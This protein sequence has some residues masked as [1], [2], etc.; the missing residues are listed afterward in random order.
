MVPLA[1]FRCFDGFGG[2]VPMFR[3]LVHGHQA[4]PINT[5]LISNHLSVLKASKKIIIS[6]PY[7]H[8]TYFSCPS[9]EISSTSCS[10]RLSMAIPT[11][12]RDAIL[13]QEESCCALSRMSLSSSLPV[14]CGFL[15]QCT[16]GKQ[17][18]LLSVRHCS[19][20]SKKFVVAICR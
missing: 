16:G 2:F 13:K 18:L 4:I 3:V 6:E 5:Q 19:R 14:F 20:L 12:R 15:L 10:K 17:L 7:T 11:A 8:G 1:S 9:L